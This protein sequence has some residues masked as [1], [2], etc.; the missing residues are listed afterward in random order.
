MTKWSNL[1]KFAEAQTVRTKMIIQELPAILLVAT[2]QG[3]FYL[4]VFMTGYSAMMMFA[5]IYYVSRP[6]FKD[7][8]EFWA[9]G[10]R[11]PFRG[12]LFRQD[13]TLRRH[14]TAGLIVWLVVF[15]AVLWLYF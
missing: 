9:R 13:G 4:K 5:Y 2:A 11:N 15:I 8:G 14:A 3:E 6:G 12:I 7:S 10:K 1:D